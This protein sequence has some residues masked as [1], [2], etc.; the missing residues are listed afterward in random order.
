MMLNDDLK[1]NIGS[2]HVFGCQQV[3]TAQLVSLNEK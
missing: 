3:Q 1:L 2:K